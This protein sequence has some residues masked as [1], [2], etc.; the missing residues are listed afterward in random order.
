MNLMLGLIVHSMALLIPP[1][2]VW[3]EL[4]LLDNLLCLEVKG[5][6]VEGEG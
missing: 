6:V 2:P 3:L 4:H 5:V 1:V